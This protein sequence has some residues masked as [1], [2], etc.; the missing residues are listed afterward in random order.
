MIHWLTC[1]SD[2]FSA[3]FFFF[4]KS[5]S[6]VGFCCIYVFEGLG[7]SIELIF[8]LERLIVL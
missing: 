3:D 1:V 8:R 7:L 5:A 6:Y 4:S 2:L